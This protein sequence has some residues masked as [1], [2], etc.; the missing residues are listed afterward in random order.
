MRECLP[1]VRMGVAFT[2]MRVS[3]SGEHRSAGEGGIALTSDPVSM[4]KC[5][6]VVWSVT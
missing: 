2:A 4:R 6:H 1:Y 5:V 3:T